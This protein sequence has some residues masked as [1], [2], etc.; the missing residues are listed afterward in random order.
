[1]NDKNKQ[2]QQPKKLKKAHL[3]LIGVV[4][5]AIVGGLGY[6]L[7]ILK[8]KE[9]LAESS[10]EQFA[11]NT[12]ISEQLQTECQKSVEKISDLSDENEITNEFMKYAQTCREVYFYLENGSFRPEGMYPDLAIDIAQKLAQKNK[13]KALEVLN[14]AVKLDPWE[15]YM[16]PIT[17]NSKAVIEAHID[18]MTMEGERVCFN[19]TEY[20]EKLLNELQKKNFAILLK[21]LHED[22]VVSVGTIEAGLGCPDKISNVIKVIEKAATGNFSINVEEEKAENK[23]VSFI[24]KTE[25]EDKLILEFVSNKSCL[26]LRNVLVPSVNE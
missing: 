5:C 18:S 21:S 15:Y 1:M 11:G 17:C 23:L 14:F 9:I 6:T 16:G 12:Q 7:Y 2:Q 3:I 13:A 10:Q 26:Q 4:I 25:S 8:Q 22:S 19:E 20:K 24:F